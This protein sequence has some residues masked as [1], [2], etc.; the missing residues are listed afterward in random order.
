MEERKGQW[1][2]VSL[3]WTKTSVPPSSAGRVVVEKSRLR[4]VGLEN[5]CYNSMQHW[6][7]RV[8]GQMKK[9]IFSVIMYLLFLNILRFCSKDMRI[10][11]SNTSCYLIDFCL[12]ANCLILRTYFFLDKNLPPCLR[13]SSPLPNL[14]LLLHYKSSKCNHKYPIREKFDYR[15][16][17]MWQK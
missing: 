11:F 14:L 7:F 1:E 15:Q 13:S 12:Q 6:Q 10:K 9:K 5:D 4:T 3:G 8:P 16:K 2:R 17:A